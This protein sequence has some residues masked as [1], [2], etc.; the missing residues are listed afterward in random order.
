MT[1]GVS[2]TL[3]A[4]GM[5]AALAT[6]VAGVAITGAEVGAAGG[7]ISGG[8]QGGWGG[9]LKGGLEGGAVGGLTA[10]VGGG[11]GGA[12]GGGL[13][14]AVA[15]SAAG[16]GVGAGL[17]TAFGG[18]P[19]TGAIGG[20]VSGGLSGY[21]TTGAAAPTGSGTTA[22]AGGAAAPA[23]AGAA[24]GGDLT[25]GADPLTAPNAANSTLGSSLTSTPTSALSPAG[26]AGGPG[27]F[28]TGQ[29]SQLGTASTPTA[30]QSS[31]LNGSPSGGAG[32]ANIG[33]GPTTVNAANLPSGASAPSTL[34]TA[35]DNPTTGNIGKALGAN[36]GLLTATAGLGNDISTALAGPPKGTNQLQS[37]AAQLGAL[38]AQNEAYLQNG[39]LPVGVQT[40]INQATQSAIAAIKSKYASM[41]M[42]GSSAEQQDI[43]SAQAQAQAQGAN[44]A[45]NLMQQGV[46]ETGLSSQIYQ[47]LI[48]NTMASDQNFS[49]AFTN[50]ATAVG[51]GGGGATLKIGGA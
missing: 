6:E 24:P 17:N 7:A 21:N 18:S 39:T 9:A 25:L 13:E 12:V 8:L 11:V 47:E 43:A 31:F 15:G 45:M 16:A 48:K 27:D 10:G 3:V 1:G 36:A 38:G 29:V 40:G 35:I 14:G 23:P 37:Q 28:G 49:S 41:G 4:A 44:I 42:S 2:A 22:G 20:A 34:S 32:G 51:G 19:T 30:A 33:Q 26:T 46:S 5:D 50:L